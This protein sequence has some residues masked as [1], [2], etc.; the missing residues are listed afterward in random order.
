MI[1]K[2]IGLINLTLLHLDIET[3]QNIA[4]DVKLIFKAENK[5]AALQLARDTIA[6]YEAKAARAMDCLEHGLEDGIA[7]LCCCCHSGIN[8]V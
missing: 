7:L 2:L 3:A 1:L 4:N 8:S 5:A 6:R